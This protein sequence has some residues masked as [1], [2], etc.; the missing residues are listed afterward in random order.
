MGITSVNNV[1]EQGSTSTKRIDTGTTTL[2][3]T[4]KAQVKIFRINVP[5]NEYLQKSLNFNGC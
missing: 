3:D 5:S 2:Y 1:E 4:R